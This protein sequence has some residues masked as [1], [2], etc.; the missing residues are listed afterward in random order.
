MRSISEMPSSEM[1]GDALRRVPIPREEGG[2]K[3]SE[4]KEDY[5]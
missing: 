4:K 2:G 5:P 3:P 1:A